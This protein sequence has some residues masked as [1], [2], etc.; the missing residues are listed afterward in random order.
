M[1]TLAMQRIFFSDKPLN[2]QE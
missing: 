2:Y 1:R